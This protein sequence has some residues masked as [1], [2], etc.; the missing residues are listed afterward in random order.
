MTSFQE[1][2]H[3]VREVW[4]EAGDRD[5]RCRYRATSSTPHHR[6][7]PSPS[8]RDCSSARDEQTEAPYRPRSRIPFARRWRRQAP[9]DADARAAP[10]GAGARLEAESLRGRDRPDDDSAQR[11]AEPVAL[12]IED[13]S[14]RHRPRQ[15]C[16]QTGAQP[17]RRRSRRARSMRAASQLP[18][19]RVDARRA[20]RRANRR[21]RTDLGA[22]PTID[23]VA[24]PGHPGHRA[25]IPNDRPFFPW[26]SGR[27]PC[28]GRAGAAV[29][30]PPLQ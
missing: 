2:T 29:D 30:P 20:A 18:R 3:G 11:A 10:D 4:L 19:L 6:R 25:N 14:R 1:L 28:R 8:R 24:I 21:A 7:R 13:L 15:L 22:A 5:A 12:G 26:R 23:E 17:C 16:R 9:D 27:S